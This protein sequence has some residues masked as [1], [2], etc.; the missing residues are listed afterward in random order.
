MKKIQ[1]SIMMLA[2][3]LMAG[4]T[5]T[6]CSN[7]DSIADVQSAKSGNYSMSVKATKGNDVLSRALAITDGS[8]NATWTTG[9]KVYVYDVSTKTVIGEL[10]AQED[11]AESTLKGIFYDEATIPDVGDLLALLFPKTTFDYKNQKGTLEDIAENYDYAL[12]NVT[13]TVKDEVNKTI[14]TTDAAFTNAQSIVKFTLKDLEGNALDADYMNVNFTNSGESVLL[15][16]F[17]LEKGITRGQIEILLSDYSNEIWAALATGEEDPVKV[18]V[19]INANGKNDNHYIYRKSDV[20]FGS[21]G[22]Y[23]IS[24]NMIK[25][26][27]IQ[28]A[29]QNG[30]ETK[31]SFTA[32]GKELTLSSLF[33]NDAF[34]ETTISGTAA[35]MITS[36]SMEKYGKNLIISVNAMGKSGTMTIDTV[37]NTYTWSDPT[38]GALIVLQSITINGVEIT[39]LPKSKS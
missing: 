24:V 37:G 7:E 36:S 17:D 23:T 30:N 11:G 35:S 32:M 33:Y 22:Y 21:G 4:V 31:F 18:D 20:T 12:A 29:F 28:E 10:I 27:T 25:S 9:D 26:G 6:S 38:V 1:K 19:E 8:L 39:Q 3:L 15:Q 13:I 2:A 16:S 5:V 34:G 14:T